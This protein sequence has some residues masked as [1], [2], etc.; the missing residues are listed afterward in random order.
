MVEFQKYPRKAGTGISKMTWHIQILISD[1]HWYV[2]Q[3][4]PRNRT[5]SVA[6]RH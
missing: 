1:A 3:R 2:F 6:Q 5:I 4:L